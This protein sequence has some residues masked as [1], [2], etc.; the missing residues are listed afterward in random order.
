MDHTSY[1]SAPNTLSK[2]SQ[3]EYRYES[4]DANRSLSY[5]DDLRV[6]V[7]GG[8]S[9]EFSKSSA[10]I[11]V[12]GYRLAHILSIM[13]STQVTDGVK[14][15]ATT[16]IYI[17]AA[18]FLAMHHFNQR[19]NE[20]LPFLSDRLANCNVY[21]TMD[22]RDS[23]F[24]PIQ[25]SRLLY[26][27]R[28][29]KHSL[30]H[31]Q[32]V[33]ILGD[34][35]SSS[36]VPLSIISGS[37]NI[38]HMNCAST[39]S[40][41]ENKELSPTFMR[42]VPTNAVDARAAA[43]Y[44]RHHLRVTRLGVLFIRDAYGSQ[45]AKDLTSAAKDQNITVKSV[46]Y[47]GGDLESIR[48]AMQELKETGL[49]YMFGIISA[50]TTSVKMIV[51]EGMNAGIIGNPDYSWHFGDGFAPLLLPTFYNTTLLAT[52]EEDRAIAQALSGI[53]VILLSPRPYPA[54]EQAMANMG[55]DQELLDYYISR[56]DNLT[57]FE[58]F[59]FAATTSLYQYTNYDAIMSLGIALCDSQE[60]FITADQMLLQVKSTQFEGVSG[61]VSFDPVTG[62]RTSNGLAFNVMNVV[63][64]ATKE[65]IGL[66]VRASARV[67]LSTGNVT[68]SSPFVFNGGSLQP[69][70]EL[71]QLEQSNNNLSFGI[72]AFMWSLSALAILASISFA[73][74]TILYR[75]KHVV[76]S[77][78]PFFLLM[79]CTGTL[80]MAAC[81]IPMGLQEPI[82]QAGLDAACMATPWL[83]VL[84]FGTASSS[85][86]CK[87][88]R[89]NLLFHHSVKMRRKN[90]AVKDVI[91]PF[92]LV[93][94]VNVALLISW[95]A[96]AP[97]TWIRSDLKN[98]DKY[99]RSVESVGRCGYN[100]TEAQKYFV[101]TLFAVNLIYVIIGNYQT[102]RTRMM[103]AEFN[104]T[105][106]IGLSMLSVLE[107][108]L[109][110]VPIIFLSKERPM[111]DLV[112]RSI[113]VTLLCFAI[114]L[115]LF[116]SK[117]RMI[118]IKQ[119]RSFAV[120]AWK[121]SLQHGRHSGSVGRRSSGVSVQRPPPSDSVE[122][123]RA[124]V[125]C[126]NEKRRTLSK[127]AAAEVEAVVRSRPGG[128]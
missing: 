41:L 115:P 97:L 102:Y 93:T 39:S 49:R 40:T 37:Y 100:A 1:H 86:L 120:S 8:D 83:F 69:P 30:R 109:I 89:I 91:Y 52:N 56:H 11:K 50:A 33:S 124:R 72:Q 107:S 103:P 57:T 32:P 99:G 53:G 10:V 121:T 45:F 63:I 112:V 4:E 114:L 116:V 3:Y 5:W 125:A 117:F 51:T 13:P 98:F 66:D 78:Q 24:S 7:S 87:S 113:L 18:G 108:L 43:L 29:V 73:I 31:P 68:I 75:R 106:Y 81:I 2:A 101:G 70:M 21:L 74:W 34:F 17:E 104:E 94:I 80:L 54:F 118:N 6:R 23:S 44:F 119:S 9:V 47:E 122:A 35:R 77:S 38:P 127:A 123:I 76:R 60:D 62:T 67:C 128:V 14:S 111:V 36:S 42:T 96:A 46:P 126:E 85:L 28:V 59:R 105:S 88:L 65:T 55:N 12:D 48:R 16:N 110:G 22:M 19:S 61:P 25:A 92:V 15:P 82:P 90:V 20:V 84:G 27:A 95:T 58:G 79:L 26:N 64:S 71:P